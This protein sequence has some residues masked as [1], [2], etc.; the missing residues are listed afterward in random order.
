MLEAIKASALQLVYAARKENLL[1]Q[2]FNRLA[3]VKFFCQVMLSLYVS[4]SERLILLA[5]RSINS[6]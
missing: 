2:K 5:L 1:L 6:S 4:E 3:L